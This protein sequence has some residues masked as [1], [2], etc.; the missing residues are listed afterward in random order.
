MIEKSI[1]I[2]N[3]MIAM[4]CCAMADAR[5]LINI[6]LYYVMSPSVRSWRN[7]TNSLR[8]SLNY[9]LINSIVNFAIIFTKVSSVHCK[10]G[11][12]FLPFEG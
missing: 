10:D 2:V 7:I 9:S 8:P 11:F 4:L 3:L 5:D 1:T 6:E 12:S